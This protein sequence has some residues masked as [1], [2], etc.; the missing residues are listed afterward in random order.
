MDL[1]AICGRCRE[2]N[3]EVPEKANKV[4]RLA[5]RGFDAIAE[6]EGNIEEKNAAVVARDLAVE[7]EDTEREKIIKLQTIADASVQMVGALEDR[8]LKLN[9]D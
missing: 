9:V 7:D 4:F 5:L 1:D 2:F 8:V 6:R 3:L